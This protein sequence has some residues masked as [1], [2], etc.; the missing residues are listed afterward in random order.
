MKRS[1]LLSR[2]INGRDFN[3]STP[4]IEAKRDKDLV[5]SFYDS[6]NQSFYLSLPVRV[7]LI[8]SQYLKTHSS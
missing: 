5:M 6:G 1:N 2:T 7:S 4:I 8:P 3:F